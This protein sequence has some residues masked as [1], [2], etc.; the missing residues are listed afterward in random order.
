[1]THEIVAY[2]SYLVRVWQQSRPDQPDAAVW[3]AEAEHI[4]TGQRRR[5]LDPQ[6]LWTFLNPPSQPGDNN[7]SQ[8]HDV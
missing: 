7:E 2:T 5:F 4:Q 8:T 1:M 6:D 3:H